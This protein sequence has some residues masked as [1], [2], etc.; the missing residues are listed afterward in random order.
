LV[1][2]GKVGLVAEPNPESIANKIVELYSI[3]E[4]H[5]LPHLQTEK[6]KYSWKVL[7]DTIISLANFA[8]E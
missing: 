5:F 7:T 3:G 2:D 4:A 1:P 8:G 6:L